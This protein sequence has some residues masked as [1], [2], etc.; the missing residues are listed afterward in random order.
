VQGGVLSE[1]LH[2]TPAGRV[3]GEPLALAHRDE[4]EPLL[5][6]RWLEVDPPPSALSDPWFANLYLFRAVHG[7]RLLRGA[8]PCIAGR[9]YDGTRLLIPLFQLQDAPVA[10]VR[11]LLREHDAFGPLSD[12]QLARLDP[13]VYQSRSSRD[14]ADYLYPAANFLHYRGT[15]LNKKRNLVKQLLAAHG[16]EALPYGP[17]LAGEARQVLDGWVQAKRQ[18]PGATD[19]MACLEALALAGTLGLEGFLYRVDG[20][21]AGFVLAQRIREG[22]YVMRFA[23][24]DS[25][26]NGIYQHMFQHFCRAVP[27]ARWLNFEQDLGL[28]NFRQTKL[29]YQPCALLAKHRVTL[30][31]G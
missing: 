26:C 18:P 2:A 23:K 14:D 15:L 1:P 24:G 27:Q 3:A 16:V 28:A 8:C 5:E 4:V 12:A 17:D 19:D 22:V 30:R 21:A 29:S 10:A 13:S 7:W 20:R 31:H 6:R 9:A 25:A 11:E